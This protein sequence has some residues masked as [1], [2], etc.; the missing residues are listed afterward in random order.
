MEL[1]T[2]PVFVT[3]CPDIS[4]SSKATGY[5]GMF[6]DLFHYMLTNLKVIWVSC[7][8]KTV[9][10]SGLSFQHYRTTVFTKTIVKK[11]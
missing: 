3:Q 7:G 4:K 5:P 2:L 10:M 9:R 1:F 8:L 6:V 11:E